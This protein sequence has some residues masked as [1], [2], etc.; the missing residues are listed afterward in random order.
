MS[1]PQLIKR[2]GPEG[3]VREAMR[4][5]AERAA[6][7]TREFWLDV[8]EWLNLP[9]D[10]SPHLRAIHADYIRQLRRRL[11]IKPSPATV[12]EQTRERVRRFR[13]R[14]RQR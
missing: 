6:K 7:E 11:G 5:A 4:E 14:Q 3:L 10:S 13:A 9:D 2:G 8:L 12:R 1:L